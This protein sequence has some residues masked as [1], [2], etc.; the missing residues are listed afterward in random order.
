MRYYDKLIFELSREGRTGYSLRCN[1]WTDST[2]S[3]PAA[4]R[5]EEAPALPQAVQAEVAQQDEAVSLGVVDAVQGIPALPEP[6]E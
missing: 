3:L 5:R 6:Q 1:E 4:L 2:A